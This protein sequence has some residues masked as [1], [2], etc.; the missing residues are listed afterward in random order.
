M[1]STVNIYNM[2]L[3]ILCAGAYNHL[4]TYLAISSR[5]HSRKYTLAIKNKK[6]TP[7]TQRLPFLHCLGNVSPIFVEV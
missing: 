2:I 5:Q 4:S 7:S 3:N 1:Q 6:S